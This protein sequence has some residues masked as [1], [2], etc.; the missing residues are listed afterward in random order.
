MMDDVIRLI[1]F[2]Y[3][4]DEYGNQIPTPSERQVFCRVRSVGRSE[5]Y[6]AAQTELHPEY[7][8]VLSH[9]KDYRGEKYAKYVDWTGTEKVYSIIRTYRPEGSDTVELTAQERIGNDG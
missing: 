6:S 2:T 3:T 4:Y 9:Y 7:V 1:G 8:F 5:F